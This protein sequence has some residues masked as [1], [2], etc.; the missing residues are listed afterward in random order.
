MSGSKSQN[1]N[2]ALEK[3]FIKK[4]INVFFIGFPVA[5]F[6]KGLNYLSNLY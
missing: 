1:L 2:G 3:K 6:E 5:F 4:V